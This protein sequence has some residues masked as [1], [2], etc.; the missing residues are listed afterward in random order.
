MN[1]LSEL[2]RLFKHIRYIEIKSSSVHDKSKI[3]IIVVWKNILEGKINYGCLKTKKQSIILLLRIEQ[4][5]RHSKVNVS[6]LN[7]RPKKSNAIMNKTRKLQKE[8]NAYFS[9]SY[10]YQTYFSITSRAI[11]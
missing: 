8:E 11:C 1:S 3:T 5:Q 10:T 6:L 9:F 2:T 7:I 4:K